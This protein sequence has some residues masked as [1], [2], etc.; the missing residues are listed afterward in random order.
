MPIDP[1]KAA[2]AIFDESLGSLMAHSIRGLKNYAYSKRVL[3]DVFIISDKY[4]VLGF[5]VNKPSMLK[6]RLVHPPTLSG[7]VGASRVDAKIHVH[8]YANKMLARFCVAH[9]LFHLIEIIDKY[10]QS[11]NKNVLPVIPR[12]KALEDRCNVFARDL[13]MYHDK[14]NKNQRLRDEHIYFPDKC[15]ETIIQHSKEISWPAGFGLDENKPFHIRPS[16]A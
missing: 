9:E 15:F 8:R 4:G 14:F 7:Y 5:T 16:L 1:T 12:N 3:I 10:A 2:T 6:C 13:C 11:E